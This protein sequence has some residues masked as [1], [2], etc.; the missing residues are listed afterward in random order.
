M[1][2][3]NEQHFS[4]LLESV[5]E[6]GLLQKSMTPVSREFVVEKQLD[7]RTGSVETF[8]ICLA[9]PHEDLIPLKIYHVLLDPEVETCTV[10]DES[11]ETSVCPMA[12]FLPIELPTRIEKL[13][14][15][16]ELALG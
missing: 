5:K 13:I 2:S 7:F 15:E 9:P 6:V 3:M 16:K 1:A 11:N 14:E 10:T 4:D 8:A 12:W